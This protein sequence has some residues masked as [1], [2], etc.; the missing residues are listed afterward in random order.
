MAIILDSNIENAKKP[1]R[2]LPRVVT[3]FNWE[4]YKK[5]GHRFIE[6]WLEF[7]PKT[8][9]LTVF[10]EGEQFEDFEFPSGL[11]WRPIEEVE[12]LQDFLDGC[13]RFPIFNG[14]LGDHYDINYDARMGRKTFMQVHMLRKHGGKVFW[15]DADSITNKHVPENFLDRCLPDD[16][17]SCFLGRDPWYFTESG[18]IGFNAN[19]PIAKK[20][21]R[22]YAHVFIVGSIFTQAPQYNEKGQYVGGGW[23]DCIAFDIIR[24]MSY[25]AGHEGEFLNLAAGVPAGTMHPFQN[26]A[27][28]EY[29]WHLKGSRKDTG[30][31]KDGDIIVKGD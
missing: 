19:H 30:E 28:G 21:L 27:P 8:V 20:F 5:Y 22:D 2:S 23:H 3:S 29:M 18:F 13:R 12:F 24:K 4:G 25:M 1:Q 6:T 26:C 16:K 31:L 17:F 9:A 11:S 10:Y 15:I 7:W 14:I